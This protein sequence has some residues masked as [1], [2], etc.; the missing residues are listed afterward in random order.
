MHVQVEFPQPD[1][2]QKRLVFQVA[3]NKMNLAD[4]V[5]CARSTPLPSP[6]LTSHPLPYFRCGVPA[7]FGL[8]ACIAS[9]N[10]E[11]Y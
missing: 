11:W 3:T 1:R 7:N 4:E 2:R 5:D 6:P 8:A 10:E 9:R